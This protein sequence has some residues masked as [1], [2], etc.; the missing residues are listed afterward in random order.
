MASESS[1]K[2]SD[3][4]EEPAGDEIPDDIE[5]IDSNLYFAL[6]DYFRD[7]ISILG[8]LAE[9]EIGPFHEETVLNLGTEYRRYGGS[10]MSSGGITENQA[11][12][13][14][15]SLSSAWHAFPG[16]SDCVDAFDASSIYSDEIDR[17]LE[18]GE[19]E[20]FTDHPMLVKEETLPKIMNRYLQIRGEMKFDEETFVETYSA[21]EDYLTKDTIR[22]QSLALLSNFEM[23]KENLKLDEDLKL[24]TLSEDDIE[25]LSG[26]LR[27]QREIDNSTVVIDYK[28]DVNKFDENVSDQATSTFDDVI[29][30]LRLFSNKGDVSYPVIITNPLSEFEAEGHTI[31]QNTAN[32]FLGTNY[33][34][35]SEESEEFAEFW[36][37]II[38]QIKNPD[39]NYRVA[40]DKFSNSFHRANEND[41]LLD[42][43]IALESLF[44]KS[45][46]NQE[47]SYRLSQRGALL[48][49]DDAE[50]ALEV[51]EN[52]REAY[53]RR[54]RLVHGSTAET[55]E[56]FVLKLHELT[57]KSLA[58]FL[59][60]R[61]DGREH[62]EIIENLDKEASIPQ[63]KNE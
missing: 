49:G 10:R 21:F 29:L 15:Q 43:V 17:A 28:F 1:E 42:C 27:R 12:Y 20:E 19:I 22:H 37:I 9:A 26:R 61:H 11:W 46:E 8:N 50:N 34:L 39:D 62:D 4:A 32:D 2:D 38:D 60:Q 59:Q 6:Q 40:L 35:A 53:N 14:S 31:E 45:G 48:L 13:L 54:S 47:M 33:S 36:N 25:N 7:V 30:A 58:T 55:D 41:R 63:S 51:K 18:R 5:I 24:R 23:E 56:D 52:L 3:G 16:F 57:R 44:L